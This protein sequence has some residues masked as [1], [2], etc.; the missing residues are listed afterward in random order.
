MKSQNGVSQTPCTQESPGNLAYYRLFPRS[1]RACDFLY[2]KHPCARKDLVHLVERCGLPRRLLLKL[3][4]S[5][6]LKF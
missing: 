2:S 5:L 6:L 3:S 4:A 1:Q